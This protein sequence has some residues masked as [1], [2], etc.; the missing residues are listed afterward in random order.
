MLY[1]AFVFFVL[2]LIAGLFGFT[3][4]A[5]ALTGAAT[6]LFYAFLALFVLALVAGGLRSLRNTQPPA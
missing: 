1:Y 5:S 4:I 3:G 2:A 6:I